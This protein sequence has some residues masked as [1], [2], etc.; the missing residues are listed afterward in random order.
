M[1]ALYREKSASNANNRPNRPNRPMVSEII[2][3]P[4]NPRARLAGL[5]AG[6]RARSRQGGSMRIRFTR[7][8]IDALVPPATGESF[9][10]CTDLPGW[11]VRI[12]ASGRRS[13]I[14]QYRDP[15]GRSRRHT[16]GDLRVVPFTLAEQRAKELLA[17][18][19]LGVDLLS[20]EAA[21]REKRERDAEKSI[22]KLVAAYLSEPDVKRRRSFGEVQRYLSALWRP[23]HGE[24]AETVSRHELAPVLRAIASER[25]EVTANRARSALSG[26]FVHAIQHG[27][28]KRDTNPCAFLPSWPER[29]RE[30]VLTLD[31]LAAVWNAAPKVTPTFG[32]IVRLLI[33]VGGR[34]SE[35]SD[36]RWAE[37]DFDEAVIRL[38]GSRVKNGRAHLIPLAPA[39]RALLE[40]APRI[41]DSR[42]FVGLSSWSWAKRKLD[43]LAP[44]Q[45]AWVLHDIRRSCRTLWREKLG[46]DGHLAELLLGHV[47]PGIE[48]VY[49]RAE[50][51][52]DRR[53]ALEAWARL[54]MTAAGAPAD[55][56][57][58]GRL[59]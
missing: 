33:L 6:I 21:A 47:R 36:L 55:G 39:A 32:A 29:A 11:G 5:R 40:G 35:V 19:K 18:A 51:L 9:A 58:V 12:L 22:G 54:V 59:R 38:P 7:A 49:D 56:A 23:V 34:R 16:I 50:R 41:S 53:R 15:Q 52:G 10:W 30:R 37:I 14:V 1:L 24:S 13:W 43:E 48:S 17:H 27:L 25:G 44:I 42:V 28:L 57:K 45:P 31:E 46:L 4:D 2:P 20:T 26:M 3:P 8:N